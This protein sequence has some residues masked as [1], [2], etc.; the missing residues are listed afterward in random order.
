MPQFSSSKKSLNATGPRAKHERKYDHLD[1]RPYDTSASLTY[2]GVLVKT[3]KTNRIIVTQPRYSEGVTQRG[4]VSIFSVDREGV[5][6]NRETVF[7]GPNA[8]AEAGYSMEVYSEGNDFTVALGYN[9]TN[10]LGYIYVARYTVNGEATA[11]THSATITNP[12]TSGTSGINGFDDDFGRE[13]LLLLNHDF[14]IVGVDDYD[15]NGGSNPQGRY[16]AFRKQGSPAGTWQLVGTGNSLSGAGGFGSIGSISGRMIGTE[17]RFVVGNWTYDLGNGGSPYDGETIE[18]SI[19]T[20]NQEFQI[21]TLRPT[22]GG[23]FGR[24]VLVTDDYTIISAPADNTTNPNS[25]RGIIWVYDTDPWQLRFVLYI[26]PIDFPF[27]SGNGGLSVFGSNNYKL[28]VDNDILYVCAPQARS[29]GG[30]G[31]TLGAIAKYD[32]I[33]GRFVDYYHVP[34]RFVHN[35]Q[36]G[37]SI[38]VYEG[39]AF[40]QGQNDFYESTNDSYGIGIYVIDDLVKPSTFWD[41]SSF[42]AV[43]ALEQVSKKAEFGSD[44]TYSTTLYGGQPLVKLER[45]S[46]SDVSDISYDLNLADDF[47]T[48]EV[49]TK[50]EELSNHQCVVYLEHATDSSKDL[51]IYI[52]P[53][54]SGVGFNN[55]AIAEGGTENGADLYTLSHTDNTLRHWGLTIRKH[56]DDKICVF[57]NGDRF[58]ESDSSGEFDNAQNYIK[59][60]L[61]R[62]PNEPNSYYNTNVVQVKISQGSAPYGFSNALASYTNPVTNEDRIKPGAG[63]VLYWEAPTTRYSRVSTVIDPVPIQFSLIHTI[64]N[65]NPFSSGS[66]DFFGRGFVGATGVAISDNYAIVGAY[67]EDEYINAQSGKAYIFNVTSG[68]LVHTLDNPNAYD[69]EVND[70]FGKSVAI[71]GNLAIVGAPFEDDAGGTSSGKAYIFNVTS[72]ALVYT[73]DNPN[74]YDTSENDYFGNSVAISG[75]RAIVGASGEDTAGGNSSGKAYIFNTTTGNLVHTLDNPNAYDTEVGDAFSRSV[76]ISGDRAIVGAANED[77]AGGLSS[78]KAYIFNVTTGALVHTLDNPNAYDTSAYDE[79]GRSVSISG[80]RAIV[81]AYREDDSGGDLSG[82]AYIFNVATGALVHTL[83]NPS[84]YGTSYADQFG[85]SVAISGNYAVVGAYD[86]DDAGAS[87]SGKAYIFNV[88]NG[89]LVYTLDNPASIGPENDE[90]GQVAI[91]GNSV[92]VGAYA[93]AGDSGTVYI[94]EKL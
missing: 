63:T 29:V 74:A 14:L 4:Q 28:S 94:Y 37:N 93:R 21:R 40:I 30:T 72:G 87:K 18:Y 26:P 32:L 45:S 84:A 54:G 70:Q 23:Q 76:A 35:S 89:E 20:G 77:D 31:Q 48:I 47:L 13:G 24:G 6:Y 7:T 78:G 51:S 53:T 88:S 15:H 83:D 50:A 65:P 42:P 71:S 33:T 16:Y 86:E 46:S 9:D 52:Q 56:D 41:S 57:R 55:S 73:L 11:Q 92:I 69:T 91:D 61:F 44:I 90:F 38:A 36:I 75:D 39:R 58:P 66:S 25:D 62:D 22:S 10:G 1:F 79:F 80:N 5:I 64:D 2:S 19:S 8:Y 67:G 49:I 68:S 82:K 59:V 17:A 60:Y 85:E 43:K 34:Q 3:T 81:G 27:K 12:D